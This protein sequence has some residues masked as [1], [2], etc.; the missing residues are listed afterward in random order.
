MSDGGNQTVTDFVL[1]QSVVSKADLS[2]LVIELERVD[3]ELTTNDVQE[4][5]GVHEH[6]AP[7]M[8][9]QLTSFITDNSLSLDDSTARSDLIKRMRK[10]KDI[11][12]VVHM[13]FAVTADRESLQQL[14]A[15]FREAVHPQVILA[16]GMQ[17]GLVAGAYVRTPN[18]V[19]DMSLRAVLGK[20]HGVLV[21]ELEHLRGA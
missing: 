3:N 2:R 6:S 4:H 16:V 18:R 8:S 20:N 5:A 15:W 17:P 7:V 13:T 9:E 12:P 1:P 11:A 19:H 10:F 21:E 14:V